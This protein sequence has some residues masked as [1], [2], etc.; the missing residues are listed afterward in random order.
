[1]VLRQPQKR[2]NV[3]DSGFSPLELA[4]YRQQT[5]SLAQ[6]LRQSPDELHN[7]ILFI[8]QR[9]TAG[10]G[11]TPV[12]HPHASA[13]EAE[14]LA[15]EV[16]SFITQHLG[17]D[18]PWPGN[19]RELEQCVRNILIRGEYRPTQMPDQ[20]AHQSLAQAITAGTLTADQLLC[21]YCTLVHAQTRNYEET[22][23][24]LQLDRRTVKSKIDPQLLE[25]LS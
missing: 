23:R 21:R 8:A 5:P 18:Y 12:Q 9:V 6:I 22:A 11:D 1:M 7:M 15:Q 4:D 19:F 13:D 25:E 14:K 3:E 17:R 16:E 20:S 2:I 10:G 24:R